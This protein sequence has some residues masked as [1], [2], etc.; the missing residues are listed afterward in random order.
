M[1]DVSVS[2]M[3]RWVRFEVIPYHRMGRILKFDP[4]ELEDWAY[5]GGPNQGLLKKKT[6]NNP[7]SVRG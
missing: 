3:R 6:K 5:A 2:T 4:Q 1:F 7:R